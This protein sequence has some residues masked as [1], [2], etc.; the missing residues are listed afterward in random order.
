MGSALG[1]RRRIAKRENLRRVNREVRSGKEAGGATHKTQGIRE[2]HGVL[3]A[4]FLFIVTVLY[5]KVDRPSIWPYSN[6]SRALS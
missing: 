2:K 4:F 1:V 5:L 3:S 6:K